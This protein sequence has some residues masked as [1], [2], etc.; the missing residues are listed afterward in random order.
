MEVACA[1]V[2]RGRRV[3]LSKHVSG[4][5][6]VGKFMLRWKEWDHDKCPRCGLPEDSKHVWKCA[7]PQ[8]VDL[9][10]K[11]ISFI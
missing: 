3:F 7:N 4:M 1:E 5:C 6:G 8:V 10:D 9:W 11:A 2:S